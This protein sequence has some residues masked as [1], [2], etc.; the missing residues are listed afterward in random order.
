MDLNKLPKDMF[1]KLICTIEKNTREE[2]VEERVELIIRI[3]NG[4]V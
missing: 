1:V 2:R 3:I 4:G